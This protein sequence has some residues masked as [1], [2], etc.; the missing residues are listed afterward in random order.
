MSVSL[1]VALFEKGQECFMCDQEYYMHGQTFYTWSE[2]DPN[3]EDNA[4]SVDNLKN[5]DNPKH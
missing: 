5:E 2:L 4:K 3:N 1:F